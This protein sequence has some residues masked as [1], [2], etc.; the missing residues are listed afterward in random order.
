MP[1][2]LDISG[3]LIVSGNLT[4]LNTASIAYLS[5][6]YTTS[7]F[8]TITGSVIWGSTASINTVQITGSLLVSGS[9]T[10]ITGDSINFNSNNLN[11]NS[12]NLN[13]YSLPYI[14][15]NDTLTTAIN[16]DF[17]INNTYYLMAYSDGGANDWSTSLQLAINS[18]NDGSII[19]CTL[20]TWGVAEITSPINITKP[21]KILLGSY[22][23]NVTFNTTPSLTS[24][25]FNIKSNGVTI[26]GFSRSPKS[27]A[28]PAG[29]TRIIMTETGNGYHIFGTG[30]NDV[31]IQNLDLLGVQSCCGPDINTGVGGVC[32]IEPNPGVGG[33]GNN[34]NNITISNLFVSGTRDHGIYFVGSIM[35]LVEDCRVTAAA[36]HSFFTTAGSTSTH[37][38]NC[39][40]SSGNLAGFCLHDTSYS[41]LE[42]CAAEGCGAGYWLRN[43]TSVSIIGCGA[44]EN[45]SPIDTPIT[46]LGIQ[47]PNST[48]I[49]TV[50]DWASDSGAY[51]VGTSYI[52]ANGENVVLNN[53]YSR[54]P[55]G[56]VG[57]TST[58]HYVLFGT[59]KN[60]ILIS[61][62]CKNGTGGNSPLSYDIIIRDGVSDTTLFFDPLTEG[63]VTPTSGYYQVVN[64]Y[65]PSSGPFQVK[66]VVSDTGT[67]TQIYGGNYI[68]RDTRFWRSSINQG[69][70]NGNYIQSSTLANALGQYL[71][72]SGNFQ[73]V[74]GVGNSENTVSKFIVGGGNANT[75]KNAFRV[76]SDPFLNNTVAIPAVSSSNPA[77]NM[78]TSGYFTTGSMFFNFGV[79][80]YGRLYAY[81]G[82]TWRY[83]DFNG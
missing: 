73:T 57:G 13:Q 65:Q 56:S 41:T 40:A 31:L 23:I 62:R 8:N 48:G 22:D 72:A 83:I 25:A 46:D 27:E 47:F 16:S 11:F 10:N 18:V 34:T 82:T 17:A 42:S 58:A 61:P 26:Q 29:Q 32:F 6:T 4:V 53:P 14:N 49:Y 54:D 5:A 71:T 50:D 59:A 1:C 35:S 80:P 33:G 44:E 60:T 77:L 81:N 43:S 74:V 39:Y 20:W 63:T 21:V 79:G 76:D 70:Q 7:S 67:R 64:V 52:I 55:N 28:N 19:D 68:F 2:S 12:N 15:S 66:S 30:S 69:D 38:R 45:N 9:T 37:F 3:S 36:G 78:P 75:K 51:V 24:N